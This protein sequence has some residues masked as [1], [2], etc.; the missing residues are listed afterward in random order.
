M[1]NNRKNIKNNNSIEIPNFINYADN[2]NQS[3]SNRGNSS[4][5]QFDSDEFI[6]EINT[7]LARQVSSEIEEESSVIRKPSK[8]KRSKLYKAPLFLLVILLLLCSVLMFT[9]T[10]K[11]MIIQIAGNYIY[12]NLN[13]QALDPN[14]TT[15]TPSSNSTEVNVITDHVINI[16]LIG[17]EENGGAQNTDS[18]IVATM[19]TENHSL[20]LTSLMRDL[21]VEIPGYNNNKLN[22]AY[23]KGGIKL[24]YQTIEL[25]FGLHLNG[26][27]LVNYEAF[28]QIV[29]LVG[30][31]DITLTGDEAN[32]LNRTNYISEK[33]NRCVVAGSQLMNGN[34]V[35]GYCRVRYVSTGTENN[36]FGRT[37]RQRIVLDAIYDKVK[38]KNV[39]SLVLLMNNILTQVD[40]E[41][42]IT[43]K[44]FNRYLEEA[45]SLKVKDLET[46]R[47]PT[48]GSFDNARVPIGSHNVEVLKPKDWNST[49][50]EI[51]TFIYGD[52]P[53]STTTKQ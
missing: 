26:Y 22:S 39:F 18:M 8:K 19:N 7:S 38:S 1:Q 11:R 17:L 2:H 43:N 37:Q 46:L 33:A 31:V 36:D 53:N 4:P 52:Q 14:E 12:N 27:C 40:F 15:D 10:G 51:N 42:N 32:Y 25:N 28:E 41:T 6:K 23:S 49:R 3:S 47:I 20:K 45:V 13:Y 5:E 9:D 35:L 29:D 30:G 34:Q 48:D 50:E 24:L 44:E 21:Y 16:L